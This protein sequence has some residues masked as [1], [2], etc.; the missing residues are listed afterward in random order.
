MNHDSVTESASVQDR[1]EPPGEPRTEG[2]V[3]ARPR[4]PVRRSLLSAPTR[5]PM[6]GASQQYIRRPSIARPAGP[7]GTKIPPAA[8]VITREE[9]AR[10]ASAPQSPATTKPARK[11]KAKAKRSGMGATRPPKGGMGTG[12]RKK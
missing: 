2:M 7:V 11:K 9:I 10:R 5:P 4:Q 8:R 12:R 3:G 1:P 6:R